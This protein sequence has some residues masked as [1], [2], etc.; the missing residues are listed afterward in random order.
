MRRP[1]RGSIAIVALGILLVLAVLGLTLLTAAQSER[2]QAARTR[3]RT[4]AFY[5][6]EAGI[7]NVVSVLKANANSVIGSRFP[8]TQ[9]LLTVPADWGLTAA[10]FPGG[11]QA[12]NLSGG[13]FLPNDPTSYVQVTL[14]NLGRGTATVR[15]SLKSITVG[16]GTNPV[17]FGFDATGTVAG[18][19]SRR[20]LADVTLTPVGGRPPN[21]VQAGGLNAPL[22]APLT[23]GATSLP[24]TVPDPGVTVTLVKRVGNNW[25]AVGT[26][27]AGAAPAGGPYA[28]SLTTAALTTGDVY[29][30]QYV[31]PGGATSPYAFPVPVR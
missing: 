27:P 2:F 11:F 22:L 14:P 30:A 5:V 19:V 6:A 13:Q 17:V 16:L 9:A 12:N 23:A 10:A 7:Q 21:P 4:E 1:P 3:R 26:A 24:G 20:L 18:G 29:S 8:V 15:V 28:F 25:Q 31:Q